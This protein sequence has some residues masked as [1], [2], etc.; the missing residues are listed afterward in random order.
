[1]PPKSTENS[2]TTCT[3]VVIKSESNCNFL[4]CIGSKKF[5]C[6]EFEFSIPHSKTRSTYMTYG[7]HDFLGLKHGFDGQFDGWGIDKI[8]A[9]SVSTS[10]IDDVHGTEINVSNLDGM[11]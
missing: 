1:M 4:S 6:M 3:K 2:E 8:R 11:A 9:S 5:M 10:E 7:C